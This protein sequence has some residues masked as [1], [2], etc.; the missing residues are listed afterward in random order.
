MRSNGLENSFATFA[1]RMPSR[2]CANRCLARSI[3]ASTRCSTFFA[4]CSRCAFTVSSRSIPTNS[5]ISRSSAEISMLACA[6]NF[7]HQALSG[8]AVNPI[9]APCRYSL[10]APVIA[11]ASCRLKGLKAFWHLVKIVFARTERNRASPET[12]PEA[13]SRLFPS[14]VGSAISSGDTRARAAFPR[15]SRD[16]AA[17]RQ[18]ARWR[19]VRVAADA[20]WSAGSRRAAGNERAVRA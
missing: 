5:S 10:R 15:S 8:M 6:Q 11:V 1:E 2:Y 18:A 20:P 7:G 17:Q 4:F 16:R 13:M 3:R 12:R 14:S 9:P 19:A